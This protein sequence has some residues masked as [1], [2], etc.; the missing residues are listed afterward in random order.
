MGDS[1]ENVYQE[2]LQVDGEIILKQFIRVSVILHLITDI[3]DFFSFP[4][5]IF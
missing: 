3:P 5:S 2:E 4:G 1:L